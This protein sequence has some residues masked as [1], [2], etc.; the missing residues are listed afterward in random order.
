MYT[1]VCRVMYRLKVCGLNQGAANTQLMLLYAYFKEQLKSL[2]SSS[3]PAYTL[4]PDGGELLPHFSNERCCCNS[5]P[6]TIFKTAKWSVQF[7]ILFL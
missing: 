4:F 2:L 1:E 3:L 7:Y 5:D 6:T